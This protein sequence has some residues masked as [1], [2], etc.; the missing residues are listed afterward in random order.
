[1]NASSDGNV[2]IGTTGPTAKLHLYN[3]QAILKETARGLQPS[4]SNVYGL[5]VGPLHDRS[6]TAGTYY[7]GIAFNH[8]LNYAGGT[9]YNGAPQAWIGLHC[10]SDTPGSERDSLVFATK[11]ENWDNRYWYR[12]SYSANGNQSSLATSASVPRAPDP[13]STPTWE[14]TRLPASTTV[15]M[16][17]ARLFKTARFY[18]NLP[19]SKLPQH[20]PIPFPFTRGND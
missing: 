4:I 20:Q 13:N 18:P 16:R 15:R 7:S 1:M 8:L 10:F 2:G 5:Q 9:G 14:P 6:T 3:G 11:R 17:P 19:N 12:Y